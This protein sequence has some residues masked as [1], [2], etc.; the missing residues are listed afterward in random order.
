M[1]SKPV[2]L[3]AAPAVD[4]S[5]GRM[6]DATRHYQKRLRELSGLYGDSAAYDALL[7]R[8]GDEVVYEVWEHRASEAPGDLVFGTSVMRPGRVGEEFFFTRGHQH[9]L[10]DRAEIYHC[11]AGSGVM[12]LEHPCGEV[13]AVPLAPQRIAYVPPLWIHRSVNTGPDTLITVYCYA[14]DAGQDYGVI[15]DA[16]GMRSRVVGDGAGGWRLVDNPLWRPRG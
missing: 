11:V 2:I 15:A 14:A 4:L 6:A 7:S 16:G 1:S 12:L 3:P 8:R 5:T 10:A 9:Q 13:R